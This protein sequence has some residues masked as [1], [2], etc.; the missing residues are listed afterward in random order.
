MIL[1]PDSDSGKSNAP[2]ENDIRNHTLMDM[3][4]NYTKVQ[5]AIVVTLSSVSASHF[6][7]LCLSFLKIHISTTTGKNPSIFER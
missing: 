7:V 5:R 2:Q 6:K 4:Q 3:W 1:N